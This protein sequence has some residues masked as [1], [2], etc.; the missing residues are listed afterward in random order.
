[1]TVDEAKNIVSLALQALRQEHHQKRLKEVLAECNA[2]PD[3]MAQIQLKMQ[4]LLPVVT[5]ILG[6]AFKQDN[7][8]MALMQVQ[9]LAASDSKLAVDVGRIM[10]AVGGDLTAVGEEEELEIVE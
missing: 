1:M 4:R 2:I 9:A 7:F 5:E 10:R 8:M 3:P 6:E